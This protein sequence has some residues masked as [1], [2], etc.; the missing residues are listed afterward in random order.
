ML[1]IATNELLCHHEVPPW[2]QY[3]SFHTM[4]PWWLYIMGLWYI[5]SSHV[6]PISVSHKSTPLQLGCEIVKKQDNTQ[7]SLS[8]CILEVINY[9][10]KHQILAR[11][12]FFFEIWRIFHNLIE[13]IRIYT[14]SV[15][16]AVGGFFFCLS[17]SVSASP[18]SNSTPSRRRTCTHVHGERGC[19]RHLTWN[20]GDKRWIRYCK[21][22]PRKCHRDIW[23]WR[24]SGWKKR[25]KAL[26]RGGNSLQLQV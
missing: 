16:S 21:V 19:R 17:R 23:H 9:S 22:L 25:F 13:Q 14:Y 1:L 11:D 24:R 8:I 7:R 2:N 3:R 6:G 20:A 18:K 15:L 26:S 5:H 12:F 4:D 10:L